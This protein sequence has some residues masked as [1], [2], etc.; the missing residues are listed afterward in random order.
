MKLVY[1]CQKSIMY[2]QSIMPWVHLNKSSSSNAADKSFEPFIEH[3]GTYL[4]RET[5]GKL[6]LKF[7]SNK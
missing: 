1:C 7:T 4:Y 5:K 2:L 3:A 6:L